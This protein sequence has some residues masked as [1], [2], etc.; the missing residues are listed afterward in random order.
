MI[1]PTRRAR[2]LLA[3]IALGSALITAA[4]GTPHIPRYHATYAVD[5]SDLRIGTAAFS[6]V[7]NQDGSYTYQSVTRP[8]GLLA[9]FRSDVITETSRFAVVDGQLRSLY[10][11]Y[12]HTGSGRD[13]FETIVFEWNK[14]IARSDRNGKSRTLPVKPGTYDRFLAQLALSVDTKSGRLAPGYHVLDHGV[15][16]A[17]RVGRLHDTTVETPAGRFRTV[18]IAQR[19]RTKQRVTRFWLAPK[20]DFL[21]VRMEQTEPGKATVR[22]ILTKISFDGDQPGRFPTADSP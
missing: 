6:L 12:R 13:Q 7:R 16:H 4:A 11:S 22:L 17:Y 21:P 1:G 9:L 15:I 19:G 10:Y 2:D 5:R 14:G 3:G 18:R 20:L 8:S